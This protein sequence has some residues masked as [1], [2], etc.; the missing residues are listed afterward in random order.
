VPKLNQQ[1]IVMPPLQ[2]GMSYIVTFPGP[3]PAPF[4]GSAHSLA[5][6]M[7]TPRPYVLTITNDTATSNDVV[8]NGEV[9]SDVQPAAE[10]V[11]V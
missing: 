10:P 3:M 6:H 7:S 4:A 8:S 11:C 1:H 5:S 2:P 9:P